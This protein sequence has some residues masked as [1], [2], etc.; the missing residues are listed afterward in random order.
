MAWEEKRILEGCTG[1]ESTSP[2]G[3]GMSSAINHDCEEF[4]IDLPML[5]A[6][7]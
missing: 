7:I 6:R 4:A 2:T 5:S 1:V 3:T